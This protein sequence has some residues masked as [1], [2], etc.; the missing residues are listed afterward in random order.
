MNS[1]SSRSLRA[2]IEKFV[3]Y[4]FVGDASI[5]EEHI[6]MLNTVRNKPLGSI[7][8]FIQANYRG[9]TELFEYW[10]KVFGRECAVS[11]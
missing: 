10:Y 2:N 7:G 8:G 3:N 9:N 6:I 4:F 5:W 1:D 11:F